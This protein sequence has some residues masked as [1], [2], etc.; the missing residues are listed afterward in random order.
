M[1]ILND[2]ELKVKI[3]IDLENVKNAWAFVKHLKKK[4]KSNYYNIE[5]C[6][7][8]VNSANA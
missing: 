8:T 4:T 6:R 7:H 2:K 3:Y 1:E 5:H